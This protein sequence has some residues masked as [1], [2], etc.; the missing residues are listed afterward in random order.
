MNSSC[1]MRP[2]RRAFT[3][4]E[5]LVVIAIIGI[6]VALLLPAVQAAR[7]A[8]RRATCVNNIRQFGIAVQN[9]H[10]TKKHLPQY[11]AAVMPATSPA[12]T[13]YA[14]GAGW[15]WPGVIWTVLLMP[16]M[17]E[18]ALY[19]QFDRK[20][21]M[22]DNTVN[23]SG[24]NNRA[25]AA[26][27]INTWVCPSNDTANDPI[28]R[29]RR[30]LAGPDVNN[31]QNALGLYYAVSMG[32]TQPDVCRPEYCANTTPSPTNYCC[33][34]ANFGTN[35]QDNSTGVLGRSD[36]KRSFKQISDGLSGTW[37]IGETRPEQCIYQSSFAPNFSLAGTMTPLNTFEKC[38]NPP[39]GQCYSKS[40]GFKSAHPGGA[41]FVM[42]DASAHFVSE[43]I[44]Y[45][46][47]NN[48]AT[49]KGAEAV[50]FP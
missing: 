5:L 33:Q 17:E 22:T 34:G 20:K 37:L 1:E 42:V 14:S 21:K 24:S 18:Q 46:L 32:P 26:T 48:L 6:L 38:P 11:H 2:C 3:L 28:F 25:L 19:D 50:S 8:A 13:T 23:A 44:D 36:G 35:P 45:Q 27:R 12:G 41:H 47:Y 9:Y 31:P 43:T 29:D 39:A 40:C 30:D 49:R 15:Q 10:D 4:V 16:Y 7:E